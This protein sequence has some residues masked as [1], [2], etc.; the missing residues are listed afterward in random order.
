MYLLL[1]SK[2]KVEFGIFVWFKKFKNY[3]TSSFVILDIVRMPTL[4][5]V[6]EWI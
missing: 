4:D 2:R 5:I 3:D 1:I 6:M